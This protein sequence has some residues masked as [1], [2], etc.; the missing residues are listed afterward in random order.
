MTDFSDDDYNSLIDG[1][2]HTADEL[3]GK[4]QLGALADWQPYT[5]KDAYTPRPPLPY[6]VT[7]IL[8]YPSCNIVYGGPGSLKS[9]LL[10]DMALCVAAGLPWLASEDGQDGYATTQSPVIW[11]DFDNG[12][13]RTHERF[14]A[15]GQGH[16]IHP[17]APLFYYSMPRPQLNLTS[18]DQGNA[19]LQLVATKQARLLI[20]DNLGLTIGDAEEN[21]GEMAGVMGNL[22]SIAE[23]AECA[24]IMVHHQ[25]KTNGNT[26]GV[27]KGETLRGHS[28]IEAS[29]D[30][31]LLVERKDGEDNVTIYPTK[32]RGFR[33]FESIGAWFD[34]GHHEGTRD[35]ARAR[36]YPKPVMSKLER[37]QASLRQS[38]LTEI[39]AQPGIEQKALVDA[40]RDSLA[41]LA[42]APGINKVRGTLKIMV[43]DGLLKTARGDRKSLVYYPI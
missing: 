1:N 42:T 7:D 40:V 25:R 27:R 28:S 11:V 13:R 35:L 4:A 2:V 19:L 43:K 17:D 30:L 32:V 23:D 10:A 16:C 21:T 5:L 14:D 24:V 18:F 37:E 41:V 39:M 3:A 31:A 29:L 9:M 26:D 6:L 34:Y 36:F 20:I 8:Y 12:R 15:I 22:R 33:M 38:I